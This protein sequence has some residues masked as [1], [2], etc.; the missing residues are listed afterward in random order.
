MFALRTSC[1]GHRMCKGNSACHAKESF[2]MG[3]GELLGVIGKG[4]FF[5]LT[6]YFKITVDPYA[7][8]KSNR[9]RSICTLS[10]FPQW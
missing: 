3:I 1:L 9:E 7:V 6:F 5:L 8:V 4:F 10:S 2:T